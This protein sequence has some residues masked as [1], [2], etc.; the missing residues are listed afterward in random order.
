MDA[1]CERCGIILPEADI[2]AMIA[3]EEENRR[4]GAKQV[5][6]LCFLCYSFIN[7]P[8]YNPKDDRPE[9]DDFLNPA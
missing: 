4:R 2:R 9:E 7:S 3:A 1:H 6:L 8:W 5:Q